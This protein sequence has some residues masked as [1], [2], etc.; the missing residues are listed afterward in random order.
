MAFVKTPVDELLSTVQRNHKGPALPAPQAGSV[1]ASAT[2]TAGGVSDPAL[3]QITTLQVKR[4]DGGQVY[5]VK[6]RYDSTVADLRR[7][8]DAHRTQTP[9]FAG[10]G[11][12]I[13]SAFPAKVYADQQETLEAAGLIPNAALFLRPE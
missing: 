3:A 8:L 6:L 11:Y 4:E 12:Q 2:G 5:I 10:V 13:R 1:S 7:A 9:E